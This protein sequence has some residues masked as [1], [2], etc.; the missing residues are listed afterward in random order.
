MSFFNTIANFF[1]TPT[2]APTEA[3]TYARGLQ[4]LS[5]GREIMHAN[6]DLSGKPLMS[7]GYRVP[8]TLL[9]PDLVTKRQSQA[10]RRTRE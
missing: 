5:E 9:G 8:G 3:I 10:R 6:L 2:T 4:A 7:A 1:K